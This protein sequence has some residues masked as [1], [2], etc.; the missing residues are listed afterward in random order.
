MKRNAL[1]PR[2]Y[3]RTAKVNDVQGQLHIDRYLTNFSVMFRQ[4]PSMFVSGTASTPI[5][6]MNESDKYTIY[7]RGYFWR[8]EAK[9]RPL[10]GRP[11]QVG[12]KVESG[13]YNAEEWALETTIDDR[14]RANTDAP[15]NL[16]ENATIL[17]E[18]KQM[19]REDRIW[20]SEFF[21]TG[22]WT[23]EE[24]GGTDF[25]PFNDAASTPISIIDGQKTM[26]AQSTGFMPNKMVVGANVKDALRSNA[27]IT[28]RIKYTQTGVATDAI[29]AML[30]EVDSFSVARSVY[31]AADE[32][33]DDD[34]EFIVDPN[35]IWL[36]YVAPTAGLN[37][38]TSIARFGWTG[39][40]GGAA[41]NI[42]GVITR[43][44]DDRAYSDWFHSRNA[45]DYKLVSPDL[46]IYISN[47][48]IPNSN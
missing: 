4:A 8:D 24:I 20:A 48:V 22:V 38:P 43:G 25:D 13:N 1:H 33:E 26:M 46:G 45:Y 5:P 16:E 14:Q 9:V 35:G 42:G 7:P 27:D 36:G 10:G 28:D 17:L 3:Q 39:F 41:N 31:N 40:L 47:A 19:I 34:F 30:F 32:G 29:L 2:G 12:Y 11:A 37:V 6:V 21:K 44:R 15:I 23:H 18:Q